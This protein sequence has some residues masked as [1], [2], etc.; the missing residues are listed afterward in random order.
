MWETILNSFS[1]NPRDVKTIPLTNKSPLWFYVYVENGKLCVDCAKNHK[2]S[3]N[4]T[5]RRIISST[6]EIC[7]IMHDIYKR[8]K[9]GHA[10]SKEA[11][12]ITLNSIYWYGIFADIEKQ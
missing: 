6:S 1:S 12:Q 10:V 5:Q 3:S 9:A 8:R 2:P 4:L 7:N 11:T